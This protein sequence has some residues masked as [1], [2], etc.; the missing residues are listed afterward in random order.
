MNNPNPQDTPASELQYRRES[1]KITAKNLAIEWSEVPRRR[2]NILACD[3][4]PLLLKYDY[5]TVHDGC[6][7][8]YQEI[9]TGGLTTPAEAIIYLRGFCEATTNPVSKATKYAREVAYHG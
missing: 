8:A 3:F 1:A 2:F 4:Y 7:A 5:Y 6:R 9:V